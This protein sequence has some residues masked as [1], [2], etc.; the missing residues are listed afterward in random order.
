MRPARRSP[1]RAV[2]DRTALPAHLPCPIHMARCPGS[3]EPRACGPRPDPVPDTKRRPPRPL[4]RGAS[5]LEGRGRLGAAAPSATAT[6]RR[7]PPRSARQGSASPLPQACGV[8]HAV[9][10]CCAHGMRCTP[11]TTQRS[12]APAHPGARPHRMQ[13]PAT[14]NRQ[15]ATGNRQPATG[16]H[17]PA[18]RPLRISPI[19]PPSCRKK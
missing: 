7:T 17:L 10:G 6:P 11:P 12:M 14:G 1:E 3:P 15:P 19:S 18:P 4:Q 13:P 5:I 8:R 9:C 16:K 2:Q